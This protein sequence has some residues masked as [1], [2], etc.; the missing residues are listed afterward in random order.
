MPRPSSNRPT[1][2]VRKEKHESDGRPA[3][4]HKIKGID[5]LNVGKKD[6]DVIKDGKKIYKAL[7][8]EDE[9]EKHPKSAV[10][11]KNYKIKIDAEKDK[12]IAKYEYKGLKKYKK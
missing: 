3:I 8:K 9:H 1:T 7:R 10:V 12:P 6:V 2:A 4:E 11:A 5:Y